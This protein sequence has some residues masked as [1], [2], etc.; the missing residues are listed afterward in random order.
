MSRMSWHPRYGPTPV[1]GRPVALWRW[2]VLLVL[3]P[4]VYYVI[5]VLAGDK[6]AL[7]DAVL[8]TLI[9]GTILSLLWMWKHLPASVRTGQPRFT[10][11]ELILAMFVA[12]FLF[13]V[14]LLPDLIRHGVST[15]DWVFGP[16][17][18]IGMIAAWLLWVVPS[19]RTDGGLAEW[20]QLGRRPRPKV[21]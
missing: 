15:R 8:W 16:I 10:R 4:T 19:H 13:S 2:L 9:V 20:R 12:I 3:A 17:F 1:R 14:I 5:S 6:R 18:L 21:R 11:D 7:R